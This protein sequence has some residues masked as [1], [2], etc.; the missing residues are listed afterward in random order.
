MNWTKAVGAI[1]A[2]AV[3]GLGTTVY[4]SA[5]TSERTTPSAVRLEDAGNAVDTDGPAG[6]HRADTRDDG[7]NGDGPRRPDPRTEDDGSSRAAR[8][9]PPPPPC[10]AGEDTE[11]GEDSDDECDYEDDAEDL[12]DEDNE[13]DP[14]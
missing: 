9:V 1:L 7:G 2:V 5:M 3:L 12:D 13:D 11:I 10:P 4:R 6:S 8:P 14:D